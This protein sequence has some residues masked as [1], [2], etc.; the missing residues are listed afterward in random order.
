MLEG[1]FRN[2]G[3]LIGRVSKTWGGLFACLGLIGLVDV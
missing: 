1:S 3:V 2:R